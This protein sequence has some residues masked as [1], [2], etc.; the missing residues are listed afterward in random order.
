MNFSMHSFK[1]GKKNGLVLKVSANTC[2]SLC[3]DEEQ[4]SSLQPKSGTPAN[5]LLALGK[6]GNTMTV[7]KQT[8]RRQQEYQFPS[9]LSY[10]RWAMKKE[11]SRESIK[12][13]CHR[14]QREKSFKMWRKG[15][16]MKSIYCRKPRKIL[17]V[18]ALC[19]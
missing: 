9:L 5:C 1:K 11:A 16:L 7:S 18:F 10:S 3:L 2:F 13:Y 19:S 14:K 17:Q 6:Q 4:V 12:L 15:I 8:G